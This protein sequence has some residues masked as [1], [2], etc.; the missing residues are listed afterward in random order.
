MA[1]TPKA[2]M[3][4][5]FSAGEFTPALAGHIDFEAYK[6]GSRFIENLIPE[7]QGGLKKFY[8][9]REIAV[10]TNPR[11]YVMV[12]FDGLDAPVVLVMHDGIVSVVDG[13]FYYDTDISVTVPDLY[14]LDWAQQNSVIYFAHPAC[15]PFEIR[16]IGRDEDTG[17]LLFRMDMSSFVDEPYFP[18]GWKGNFGGTITTSG[19]SGTITLSAEVTASCRLKVPDVLANS[20]G[21]VDVLLPGATKLAVIDP[22]ITYGS[23]STPGQPSAPL[24]L[25]KTKV[26]IIRKR[27]G[28][29]SVVMTITD[30]GVRQTYS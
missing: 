8:G 14:K 11:N 21:T 17:Q 6:S 29:E 7:V 18:I 30:A 24:V 1:N 10:L 2:D 12:P 4:T 26:S 20:S 28:V 9:T 13:D 5:S 16:H 15:M 22:T 3:I 19:E 27:D 23:G 25:G